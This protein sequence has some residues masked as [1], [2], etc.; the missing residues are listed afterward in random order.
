VRLQLNTLSRSPGIKAVYLALAE[1]ALENLP[2][3]RDHEIRRMLRGS[4]Q[5]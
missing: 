2:H 3:R 1:A 5:S 4:R